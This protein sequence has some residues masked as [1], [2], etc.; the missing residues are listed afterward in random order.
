MIGAG[1]EELVR[2]HADRLSQFRLRKKDMW[3]KQMTAQG[4]TVCTNAV[5]Q[6]SQCI[7]MIKTQHADIWSRAGR[8][9]TLQPVGGEAG[10]SSAAAA[11]A[12][13]SDA[14]MRSTIQPEMNAAVDLAKTQLKTLEDLVEELRG[15]PALECKSPSRWSEKA[16]V[17][18]LNEDGTALFVFQTMDIHMRKAEEVVKAMDIVW[19]ALLDTIEAQQATSDPGNSEAKASLAKA[20]Q[21]L[22]QVSQSTKDKYL[23][24]VNLSN[25]WE[26]GPIKQLPVALGRPLQDTAEW[27]PLSIP[28]LLSLSAH[29]LTDV[30]GAKFS[31]HSPLNGDVAMYHQ[32]SLVMFL[33]HR[34]L[35]KAASAE[36]LAAIRH[37]F[38]RHFD[39]SFH[40]ML[41]DNG[42]AMRTQPLL[43]THTL[44]QVSGQRFHVIIS[45]NQEAKV[46]GMLLELSV[47]RSAAWHL[48]NKKEGEVTYPNP[49]NIIT[50][51]TVQDPSDTAVTAKL[52]DLA[53]TLQ[54]AD[55]SSLSH[56]MNAKVA[57][58][59]AYQ[60]C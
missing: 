8:V 42:V 19:D 26:S 56:C 50:G 43:A 9:A 30:L 46:K 13:N 12:A 20:K 37:G 35:P 24:L 38:K 25:A 29:N 18:R 22:A 33:Y 28:V 7:N 32:S 59:L 4:R 55:V 14:D 48:D 39:M 58:L 5:N 23:E 10:G 45:P 21:Q 44:T 11:A 47:L 3:V 51:N 34:I 53:V 2:L 49:D 27:C 54:W 17:E 15:E 6:V 41:S 40:F 52:A 57:A 60:F 16:V 1:V 36:Q 31:Q